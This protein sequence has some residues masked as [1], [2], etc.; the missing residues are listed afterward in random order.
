MHPAPIPFVPRTKL[1]PPRL[2]DDVV[3]RGR[4]LERLDRLQTFT[5]IIAPAGYGKTTLVSTWLAR[6]NRPYAWLS[7]EREDNTPAVFL[8]G[9]VSALRRLFPACGGELL[10]LLRDPT[11][12][13][14]PAL[15]LPAL[16]NELDELD[17]EFVLVLDDYHHIGDTSIHEL[18]WGLLTHPPRPLQLV[19]T[20]RHDPPIPPR[21]RCQGTGTEIRAREL[22]FTEAEAHEFLGRFVTQPQDAQSVASLMEQSEGWAV[23]LRLVAILLDQRQGMI[24]IEA[25]LHKCERSLLDYLDAE[26]IGHLPADI[27]TFLAYTSLLPRLTGSLCDAVIGGALPAIDSA[28]LLAELAE[29]G[30]FTEHLDEG[31]GW[32]RYHELFRI[33]LQRRL[34]STHDQ[35]EIETLDGRA[36]AWYQQHGLPAES[37]RHTYRSEVKS[38]AEP[39]MVTAAARAAPPLNG[40]PAIAATSLQVRSPAHGGRDLR[41]LVTFREMDV[42]LL[43]KQRL[44]NKEIARELGISPDTVRQHTAN[45]YRK[46]GVEN[47][48]QA[49][50]HADALGVPDMRELQ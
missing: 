18:L 20:A 30:V 40:V 5:L 10:A 15:V 16:L 39:S 29:A 46:L 38:S 45:L 12:E 25:A 28:A 50:V 4:L 32:F 44:T 33:L 26:V 35:Q 2:P 47:R 13:L 3:W 34:R 8:A 37:R 14:T 17:Q 1:R 41:E 27:Q 9:F 43:L 42:L 36:R 7:L 31:G 48:R 22:C 11:V 21:I 6:C 23:P 49:V 24:S 19:L